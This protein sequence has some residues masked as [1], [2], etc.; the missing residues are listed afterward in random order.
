M[1]KGKQVKMI[2]KQIQTNTIHNG[3]YSE[4]YHFKPEDEELAKHVDLKISGG[5][6][7][8]ERLKRMGLPTNEGD[9]VV[10]ETG[11]TEVQSKIVVE[12]KEENKDQK[13]EQKE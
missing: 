2:L 1:S 10:I 4:T 6:D 13:Q 12:Q 11:V 5:H 7:A 9:S 3:A 8:Q